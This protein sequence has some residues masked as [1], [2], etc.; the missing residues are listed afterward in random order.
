MLMP[1]F[2]APGGFRSWFLASGSSAC[3]QS[4]VSSLRRGSIWFMLFAL[5]PRE[6]APSHMA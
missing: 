2:D 1:S 5:L 4:Y 6:A 3:G